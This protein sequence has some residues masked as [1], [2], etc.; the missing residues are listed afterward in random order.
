[1]H[2]KIKFWKNIS[3]R[4]QTEMPAHLE[5]DLDDKYYDMILIYSNIN[6][7]SFPP[8]DSR[9]RVFRLLKLGVFFE[10]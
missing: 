8:P 6:A 2:T 3:Q 10:T 1:M 4:K 5:W 7:D 9:A